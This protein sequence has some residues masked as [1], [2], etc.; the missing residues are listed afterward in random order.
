MNPAPVTPYK[1]CNFS[2]LT[3]STATNKLLLIL[4]DSS[5]YCSEGSVSQVNGVSNMQPPYG[6]KILS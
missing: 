3:M 6:L 1:E 5:N 2:I 4:M